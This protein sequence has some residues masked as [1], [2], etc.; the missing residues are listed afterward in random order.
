MGTEKK[1]YGWIPIL[2]GELIIEQ[3]LFQEADI[4]DFEKMFRPEFSEVLLSDRIFDKMFKLK[5]RVSYEKKYLERCEEC[6]EK[7]LCLSIRVS[8]RKGEKLVEGDAWIHRSGLTKYKVVYVC[9]DYPFPERILHKLVRDIFH[10][11]VHHSSDLPLPPVK[12]ENE[13]E[14]KKKILEEYVRKF[15]KYKRIASKTKLKNAIDDFLRARGEIVYA[16]AAYKLFYKALADNSS[17]ISS[18]KSFDE[19][20]KILLERASYRSHLATNYITICLTT[21]LMAI[22]LLELSWYFPEW[23]ITIKT[24]KLHLCRLLCALPLSTFFYFIIELILIR[25]KQK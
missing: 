19:S 20:F 8:N 5:H 18:F 23:F 2:S 21:L 3:K 10:V 9:P 6:G 24:V 17:L 15:I 13:E 1:F 14:A 7:V 25:V 12:A 4:S 22:A 16:K 11:H